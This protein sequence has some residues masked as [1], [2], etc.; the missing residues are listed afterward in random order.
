MQEFEVL[1]QLVA[2]I[3]QALSPQPLA[4][5]DGALKIVARCA[6]GRRGY[7]TRRMSRT[8]AMGSGSKAPRRSRGK[9]KALQLLSP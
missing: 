1:E 4:L 5:P 8:S 2:R 3:Q 9:A 7:N 6:P